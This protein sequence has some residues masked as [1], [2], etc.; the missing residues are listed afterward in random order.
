MEDIDKVS[1]KYQSELENQIKKIKECQEAHQIDSC[2]KCKE[3]LECEKRKEYV[4]AVYKSMS[5][6]DGGGFEF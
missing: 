4:D 3:I 1:D 2:L 5:K 6:G